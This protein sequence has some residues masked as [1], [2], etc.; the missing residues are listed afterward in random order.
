[1][2]NNVFF[3]QD[4]SFQ[5]QNSEDY[6]N[7]EE[8]YINYFVKE[9][10][11]ENNGN[12]SYYGNENENEKEELK[13]NINKEVKLNLNNEKDCKCNDLK[14]NNNN[15]SY[16]GNKSTKVNSKTLSKKR[17]RSDDENQIKKQGRKKKDDDEKG[18]HDKFS[19]DNMIR[20]I[21]SNFIK[22]VH[23]TINNNISDKDS[24]L[25]RLNPHFNEILKIDFNLQLMSTTFKYL[26][27]N[28]GISSKYRKKDANTNKYL[29][30]KLYTEERYTQ[31]NVIF[32]LDKTYKELYDDYINNHLDELLNKIK[33]E[34]E[35]EGKESKESI[36]EYLEKFKNLC[37]TYE[38]W[39]KNKKGRNRMK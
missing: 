26:Y 19:E 14:D 29:I 17:Q 39:F 3:F 38:D 5:N 32:Y 37:L 9:H 34:L 8:N 23:E 16:I 13:F 11:N 7:N 22:H 21:K 2:Y 30:D 25:L 24:Q 12:N 4:N 35:K 6:D 15:I 18:D 20:K 31:D 1:M 33:N 36:A 27:E 28:I 10:G